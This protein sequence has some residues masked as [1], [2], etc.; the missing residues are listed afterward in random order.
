[1][2]VVALSLAG[3]SVSSVAAASTGMEH[4]GRDRRI[5]QFSLPG[6]RA[7]DQIA[8]GPD[9]N[10]WFT[11]D[12]GDRIGRIT[13][14]GE[15]TT[16]ADPAGRISRPEGIAEGPD[17]RLW[18]TSSDNGRIGWIST[19]GE[20]KTFRYPSVRE[21]WIITVD[22]DRYLWFTDCDY[23][24]NQKVCRHNRIDRMTTA[25]QVTMF[26]DPGGHVREP[27]GIA[28]GADGDLWFAS[29][30]NDRLGRITPTGKI[31]TFPVRSRGCNGPLG[32]TMGPDG[33]TWF[34]CNDNNR[35]GRITPAGE[36]TTFPPR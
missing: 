13:P 32:I 1:M 5:Q 26:S 11:N 15:L 10:L 14:E 24:Y 17:E 28:V 6:I 7:P 21:P 27:D 18:F 34:T 25:G 22:P 33:N 12:D 16:F 20:I 19:D 29:Y 9:G 36:V 23:D 35:I 4:Q 2:L 30:E 31:T 3:E 8:V